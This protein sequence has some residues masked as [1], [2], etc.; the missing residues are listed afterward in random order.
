MVGALS[1]LCKSILS[2]LSLKVPVFTLVKRYLIFLSVWFSPTGSFRL[3]VTV[4]WGFCL[5][6]A[7]RDIE[8]R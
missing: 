8:A 2:L 1:D 4:P 5:A 3:L 7:P 6:S